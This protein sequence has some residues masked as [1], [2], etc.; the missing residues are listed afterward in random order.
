[1][2]A[3][4]VLFAAAWLGA[5]DSECKLSMAELCGAQGCSTFDERIAALESAPCPEG[6]EL[7]GLPSVVIGICDGRRVVSDGPVWGLHRTVYAD[8]GT[9]VGITSSGDMSFSDGCMVHTAGS[10]ATCDRLM[11]STTYFAGNVG[12]AEDP[13]VCFSRGDARP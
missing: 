9:P 10:P 3:R 6:V 5:C 4:V 13:Q 2:R 12:T 11:V 1:M 7:G 8:D